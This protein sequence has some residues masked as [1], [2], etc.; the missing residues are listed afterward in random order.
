M[1]KWRH[2]LLY[3]CFQ[4]QLDWRPE[5]KGDN[6]MRHEK[7]VIIRN[8]FH[9]S[10]FEV[11]THTDHTHTHTQLDDGAHAWPR[12]VCVCVCVRAV[13]FNRRIHWC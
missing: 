12:Y 10:D 13:G 11:Q 6:R 9:P 5:K 1:I 4:R 2:G 3:L 7:V 8:M